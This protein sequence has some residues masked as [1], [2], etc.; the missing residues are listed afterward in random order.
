MFRFRL[1]NNTPAPPPAA[2]ELKGFG[3]PGVGV[4]APEPPLPLERPAPGNASLNRAN[5]GADLSLTKRKLLGKT[6]V[7][8]VAGRTLTEW[9]GE[10]VAWRGVFDRF[11]DTD[12]FDEVELALEWVW[13]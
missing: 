3:L 6:P 8:G 12:P 5:G 1:A 7:V 11:V 13:V 9:C 4:L 2:E 10:R